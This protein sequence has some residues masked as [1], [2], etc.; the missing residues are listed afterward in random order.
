MTAQAVLNGLYPPKNFQVWNKRI[1]WQPIPVHTSQRHKDDIVLDKRYSCN[2]LYK[3]R[4]WLFIT[5]TFKFQSKT[6]FNIPSIQ[7]CV[8]RYFITNQRKNRLG[9][10]VIYQNAAIKI[11]KRK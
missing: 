7:F 1:P 4:R 11:R 5:M 10:D 9:N 6:L 2:Q 8:T 3:V